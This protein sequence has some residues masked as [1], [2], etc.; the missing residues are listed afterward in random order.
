MLVKEIEKLKSL[1]D[2]GVLDKSELPDLIKALIK[3]TK[4]AV[5]QPEK[6]P[7]PIPTGTD[8]S[9]FLVC[10]FACLFI[11]FVNINDYL[12]CSICIHTTHHVNRE[13][14]SFCAWSGRSSSE[15]QSHRSRASPET[16]MIRNIIEL[17]MIQRFRLQ[18][19]LP[20]SP[21]FGTVSPQRFNEALFN[22]ACHL[23]F[24]VSH[25]AW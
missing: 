14:R 10:L 19:V 8:T 12:T 25:P 22:R 5:A 9:F 4:S 17:P 16:L 11:L 13:W 15:Q 2:Q 23:P 20:D 1:V 6:R 7:T 18:C 3:A 21:L 24:V